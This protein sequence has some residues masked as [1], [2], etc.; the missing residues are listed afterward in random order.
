MKK[1]QIHVQQEP[2]QFG[3]T[4]SVYWKVFG[5]LLLAVFLDVV[6][7][8]PYHYYGLQLTPIQKV[9]TAVNVFVLALP[10]GIIFIWSGLRLG[11][12][13]GLGV[14]LLRRWVAGD[15]LAARQFLRT[16]PFVLWIT[17]FTM[18]SQAALGFIGEGIGY[19]RAEVAFP[20][21]MGVLG[22]VG[23]GL[24]EEILYRL[25]LLTL[26][27]WV[28]TR[29]GRQ[30]RPSRWVFW[31]V[32]SLVAFLFGLGHLILAGPLTP[33]KLITIVLA[34]AVPGAMW[35]WLYWRV[36][37]MQAMLSHILH[38][39]IGYTL[40]YILVAVIAK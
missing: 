38:D 8:L 4:R 27:L 26:L 34:T 33:T 11:P 39:C 20:L 22:G 23:A 36:G 35:G 5:L 29:L 14:P 13:I 16:V 10:L 31:S 3:E 21:W 19:L 37:L 18:L 32:N 40:V 1:P 2:S 9:E 30:E 6:L 12:A 24:G 25:G 15:P 17:A 28:T 7:N